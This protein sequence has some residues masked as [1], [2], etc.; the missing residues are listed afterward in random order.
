VGP[1]PTNAALA[2]MKWG[3]AAKAVDTVMASKAMASAHA[4]PIR[5]R[6]RITHPYCLVW[7]TVEIE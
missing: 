6:S 2:L 5:R 4:L 3:L 1:L 7:S